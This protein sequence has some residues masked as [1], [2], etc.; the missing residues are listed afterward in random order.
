MDEA[1]AMAQK[2]KSEWGITNT[3]CSFYYGPGGLIWPIIINDQTM[4]RIVTTYRRALEAERSFI[5]STAEAF[6]DVLVWYIGARNP[7]RISKSKRNVGQTVVRR[8]ELVGPLGKLT[9]AE[10]EEAIALSG[11]RTVTIYTRLTQSPLPGF[12]IHAAFERSLA[13]AAR[14]SGQVYELRIPEVLFRKL[15]VIGLIERSTTLMGGVT[16]TEIRVLVPAV[17]IVIQFLV[18]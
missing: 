15:E 3:L 4:P 7:V 18:P 8:G 9:A 11:T 14:R 6:T 12:Q 16:G 2:V 13:E 10:I 1:L 5:H 17:D